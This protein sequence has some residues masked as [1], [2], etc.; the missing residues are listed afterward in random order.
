MTTTL[1]DAGSVGSTIPGPCTLQSISIQSYPALGSELAEWDPSF[2]NWGKGY[3]VL[4]DPAINKTLFSVSADD[5]G[6]L[7]DSAFAAIF[8]ERTCLDLR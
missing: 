6:G 5:V 8:I 2:N 1:V 7:R 4:V 3:F